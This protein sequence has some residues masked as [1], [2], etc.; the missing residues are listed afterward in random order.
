M[1]KI[2]LLLSI[3]LIIFVSCKSDAP[4]PAQTWKVTF[5]TNSGSPVSPYTNVTDGSTIKKP[6]DP[7][8]LNCTFGGWYI[9][10]NTY[11]NPWDF[12]KSTVTSNVTL[13][14]KW[15]T[16]AKTWSLYY[17][18][19]G[20]TEISPVKGLV[21]GSYV[22]KPTDPTRTNFVFGGWFSDN[23]V[24]SKQWVFTTSTVTCDTTIYAKW[25]PAPGQVKTY[26]NTVGL[27]PDCADPYILK[28]NGVYYL[29]GTGGNDGIRVYQSSDMVTW[30]KAIGVKNGYALHKDDVWGD[31]WFWAPEV[32]FLN[33]KFYMFFSAEEEICV[34][35][36]NSPLGPFVQPVENQQPFHTNVKEIDTH[37]F[38]DDDGKK[39]LYFVRFTN[40]NE[41]WVAELNDD[42]KSIKESTL[43]RC[44]GA[45]LGLQNWEKSTLDP[46][47]GAKVNEGPFIIKHNGW[48]YLTYSA[49]HYQNPNYGV[50]YA[51]SRSPLGPWIKYDKN[52]I[53]IGNS[54][55][56]G[57][58]HHSFVTV[59]SGCQYIVYHSHYSPTQ[60][61]AR[62]LGIDLY[63]FIP[64]TNGA[65]TLR[66]NGPTTTP[67]ILCT[68]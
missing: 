39:Y 63:E 4:L 62:K 34:A 49:N 46:Q 32:Y 37:L 42:M 5:V 30:T 36:S 20:G 50:G 25:T 54:K 52:P 68:K 16:T 28:H 65:D 29:Y 18:S 47:P 21:S 10:N 15:L 19:N 43:K 13:Y 57:T 2:H 23:L 35:E 7:L 17:N 27:V 26:D 55:I 33:D 66:V 48:Y 44:I 60:V 64:A 56:R 1:K 51:T 41:I 67:Q 3:A 40:G 14:A 22:S 31:K 58:G 8:K 12:S 53:L 61:G 45:T 59:N 24:F 38:I 11:L 9:D 6:T